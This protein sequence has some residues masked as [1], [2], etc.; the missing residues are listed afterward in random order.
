MCYPDYGKEMKSEFSQFLCV[1]VMRRGKSAGFMSQWR[2]GS[3]RNDVKIWE[4]GEMLWAEPLREMAVCIR[5]IHFHYVTSVREI[6]A[7][8]MLMCYLT[9]PRKLPFDQTDLPPIWCLEAEIYIKK[10]GFP[11]RIL[12]NSRKETWCASVTQMLSIVQFD[13]RSR[14]ARDRSSWCAWGDPRV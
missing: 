13:L 11:Q 14:L 9:Y 3:S 1:C 10:M 7:C 12:S 5:E 8:E 6:Q 4:N 2:V